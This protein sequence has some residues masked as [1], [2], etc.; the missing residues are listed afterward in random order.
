MSFDDLFKD[1]P[2]KKPE[3]KKE[4]PKKEPCPYCEKNYVNLK[5]HIKRCPKN[6][7]VLERTK[8]TPKFAEPTKSEQDLIRELRIQFEKTLTPAQKEDFT[9]SKEDQ[10]K[11]ENVI[12]FLGG[13]EGYQ[14]IYKSITGD[15]IRGSMPY[16][17]NECIE[18]LK[19][20]KIYIL[21]QR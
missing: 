9:L 8:S 7:E 4:E 6:P 3:P 13:T 1:P 21:M 14:F 20:H 16:I 15:K 18:W 2:K 10:E 17:I 12:K 19:K 5:A 11:I